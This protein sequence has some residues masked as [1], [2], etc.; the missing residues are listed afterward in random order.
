MHEVYVC[1]SSTE[2]PWFGSRLMSQAACSVALIR[3][4]K[5]RA[6]AWNL[7]PFGS[8]GHMFDP[9][10]IFSQFPFWSFHFLKASR[11]TWSFGMDISNSTHGEPKHSSTKDSTCFWTSCDTAGVCNYKHMHTEMKT[12]C[13]F[14]LVVHRLVNVN[15]VKELLAIT[16]LVVA[17]FTS[18]VV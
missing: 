9:S 10:P 5:L 11:H 12:Q 17:C 15:V 7:Q 16:W 13:L 8:L 2:L 4:I 18:K 14:Y 1:V 6:R 3:L